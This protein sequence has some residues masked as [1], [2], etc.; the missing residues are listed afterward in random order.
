MINPGE[1]LYLNQREKNVSALTNTLMGC[2]PPF[3]RGG[4][5]NRGP[6]ALSLKRLI[7]ACWVRGQ[8]NRLKYH[9]T[10]REQKNAENSSEIL[11]RKESSS[12]EGKVF[13]FTS[14]SQLPQLIAQRMCG[15]QRGTWKF[16]FTRKK[17]DCTIDHRCKSSTLRRGTLP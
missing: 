17:G 11:R 13:I 4:A 7:L 2:A 16:C 6:A 5:T 14:S 3:G 1:T 9:R 15:G 12:K 8:T 10:K